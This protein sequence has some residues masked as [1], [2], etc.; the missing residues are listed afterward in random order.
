MG[1]SC[2]IAALL[3]VLLLPYMPETCDTLQQQLNI[4]VN[5]LPKK[6]VFKCLLQAGHKI[7]KVINYILIIKVKFS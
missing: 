4:K 2:N 7:S 6:P 3:S 1:L 5:L